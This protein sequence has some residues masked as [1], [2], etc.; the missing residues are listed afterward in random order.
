MHHDA[1]QIFSAISHD[2][3]VAISH[4]VL[5]PIFSAILHDVLV[6][7]FLA[8][9]HDALVRSNWIDAPGCQRLNLLHHQLVL[10]NDQVNG[11]LFLAC[12]EQL[13]FQCGQ[14]VP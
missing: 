6:S 8:I 1:P 14:H 2:V 4:D 11:Q 7:I 3:L 10:A 12:F 9:L 13:D 5:V